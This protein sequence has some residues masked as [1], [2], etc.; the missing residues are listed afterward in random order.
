[1]LEPDHIEAMVDA[2]RAIDPDLPYED[3]AQIAASI[4]DTPEIDEHG[5]VIGRLRGEDYRLPALALFP[6]MDLPQA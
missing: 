2:I 6:E 3:A 4:G 1:M 5:R